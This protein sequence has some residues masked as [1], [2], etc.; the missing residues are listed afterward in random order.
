MTD[1]SM[2]QKL[3]AEKFERPQSRVEREINLSFDI[4]LES[5]AKYAKE[6]K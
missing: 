4:A 3:E 2:I 5:S 6:T 1:E